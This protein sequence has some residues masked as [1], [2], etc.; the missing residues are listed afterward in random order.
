MW[1]WNVS[2]HLACQKENWG[3]TLLSQLR[4]WQ[5]ENTRCWWTLWSCREEQ[6]KNRGWNI[7]SG[8]NQLV[9]S[10]W[11]WLE[12][13]A[14]GC[15]GLWICIGVLIAIVKDTRS[16]T[17]NRCKCQLNNLTDPLGCEHQ[18]CFIHDGAEWVW[19]WRSACG[20]PSDRPCGAFS[21]GKWAS[22]QSIFWT[23]CVFYGMSWTS[24][25]SLLQHLFLGQQ[26]WAGNLW[27]IQSKQPGRKID[28]TW[29]EIFIY[30][31]KTPVL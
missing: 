5:R 3:V 2:L 14:R 15:G 31:K 29:M 20:F 12:Q 26:M 9:L 24:C 8:K 21:F 23:D 18:W 6:S 16:W 11:E 10:R 17:Q 4:W 22:Q 7:E 25:T 30:W 28:A 1:D 13:F 19:V 27:R